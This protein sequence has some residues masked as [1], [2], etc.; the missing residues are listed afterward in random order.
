MCDIGFLR[1][2]PLAAEI[3]SSQYCVLFYVMFGH[4]VEAII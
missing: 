3:S 1:V 4:Y 2:T